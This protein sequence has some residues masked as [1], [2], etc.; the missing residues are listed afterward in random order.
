MSPIGQPHVAGPKDHNRQTER[1]T[2]ND[3]QGAGSAFALLPHCRAHAGRLLPEAEG[4]SRHLAKKA[5]VTTLE[6]PALPQAPPPKQASDSP[7]ACSTCWGSSARVNECHPQRE[8]KE[9]IQ[10]SNFLR[11]LA[12]S[13]T[14]NGQRGRFTQKHSGGKR[15]SA[16]GQEV[17]EHHCHSMR[18][19]GLKVKG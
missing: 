5:H 7:A 15:A 6:V 9:H 1:V 17:C 13:Q 8:Q 11:R 16:W 12:R 2:C 4:A 10:P 19:P 3:S 14:K 18:D